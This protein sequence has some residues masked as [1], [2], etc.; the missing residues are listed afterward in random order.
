MLIQ[1]SVENY[2]SIRDE[3]IINFSVKDNEY[4]PKWVIENDN[5]DYP[6]YKTIGLIGPNAS[7]KSNIL[8]SMKFAFDFI[9]TTLSRKADSK[10]SVIPFMLKDEWKTKETRFEFIFFE[11]NKKYVYGFAINS[12]KVTEEYLIEYFDKSESVI[13]ERENYGKEKYDFKGN[14]IK[15]QK[16][17]AEKTNSNRLYLAVAAEWGY[18]KVKIAYDWFVRTNREYSVRNRVIAEILEENKCKTILLDTLH[19]ADFNIKDIHVENKE[20]EPKFQEALKQFINQIVGDSSGMINDVIKENFDIR[21]IHEDKEGNEYEINLEYDS[22][23]TR[24]IVY[25]VAEFIN[26]N[27]NGGLILEDELGKDFHTR[28][29]EYYLN[30]FHN[31]DINFGS[32]QM[33]FSSHD[34]SVLNLLS[35]EQIYL[36][37]KDESGDTFV[38]LL[39]D[40]LIRET[41][42]VELG[43]L[44]GRYGAV[45]YMK[46]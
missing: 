8:E 22:S 12:D 28:L 26:M 31:T 5:L 10:I 27:R 9:N 23:G 15:K 30:L 25:N 36:V 29:T 40:Y 21:I 16:E 24:S 14:D 41:D 19:K 18:E 37:D 4:N 45:P 44:K 13:F 35:P 7:G 20:L 38:K 3:I 1:Y 34:T 43:Y 46:E 17:I 2:K 42:N 32:A 11:A 39:D 33:I 6:V